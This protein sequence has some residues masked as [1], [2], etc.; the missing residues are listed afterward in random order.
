MIGSWNGYFKTKVIPCQA[1]RDLIIK[2]REKAGQPMEVN[3]QSVSCLEFGLLPQVEI[4]TLE[5]EVVA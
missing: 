4:I 1:S 3:A 2:S 5:A